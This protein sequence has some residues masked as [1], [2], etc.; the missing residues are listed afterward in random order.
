MNYIP[1]ITKKDLVHGQYYKGRCRNAAIT[2][3]NG[4]KQRFVHWRTKF[5]FKFLEEICHPE[6]ESVFDVFVVEAVCD[7]VEEIPLDSESLMR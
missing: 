2:R 7:P 6:D 3:W 5:T 1:K 4:E